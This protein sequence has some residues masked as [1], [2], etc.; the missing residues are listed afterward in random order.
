MKVFSDS[1]LVVGQVRGDLEACD[2]RMQEYL[3]QIRSIQ[4]NFEVFDLFHISKSE[5]H[6][7]IRWPP[8]PCPRHMICPE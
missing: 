6:M 8:L 3:C 5:T 2:S 4:E 1:K 7:Q